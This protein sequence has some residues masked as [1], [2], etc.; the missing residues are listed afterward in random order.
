[1]SVFVERQRKAERGPI[2]GPLKNARLLGRRVS[3]DFVVPK[4]G[5]PRHNAGQQG[6]PALESMRVSTGNL[7]VCE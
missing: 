7:T 5:P 2:S 6:T 4:P 1:M 3:E